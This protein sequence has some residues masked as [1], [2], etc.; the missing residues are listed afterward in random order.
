MPAVSFYCPSIVAGTIRSD[1]DVVRAIR[2]V[3]CRP[4]T[5]CYRDVCSYTSPSDC[6]FSV[7]AVRDTI[8]GLSGCIGATP[9]GPVTCHVGQTCCESRWGRVSCNRMATLSGQT[10][11]AF[12]CACAEIRA[13]WTRVAL[14]RQQG[15]L[16][17]RK[18]PPRPPNFYH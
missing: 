18:A 7:G 8:N 11:L 4:R 2:V 6:A 16:S 12:S 1:R 10:L 3:E 14:Y 15:T 17:H 13:S 5:L 9:C